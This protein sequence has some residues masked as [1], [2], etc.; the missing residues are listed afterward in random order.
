MALRLIV[1]AGF[2]KTGTTSIQKA[3]D[4]HRA[5]IADNDAIILRAD[6]MALCEAARA[7]SV[8]RSP[9]DLGIVQ[10]EASVLAEAWPDAGAVLLSSEDLSGHMPGRR[11]LRT[12]VAAPSLARAM[13]DT[14]QAACP[15]I[16]IAFVYTTRPAAPWLASCHMQHLR[17]TR[18]TL[19]QD[20]YAQAFGASADLDGV[21]VSTRAALLQRLMVIF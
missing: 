17:S 13:A 8:S 21:V 1:H 19:S 12:Y 11:G 4:T 9:L 5:Y 6:M 3:L 16:D 15:G 10:Y 20:G 2:H 18:M 7:Y 14:W